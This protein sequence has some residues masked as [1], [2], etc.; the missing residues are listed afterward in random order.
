MQI[1]TAFAA[2]VQENNPVSYLFSVTQIQQI[3][4]ASCCNREGEFFDAEEEAAHHLGC[5]PRMRSSSSRRF[6]S[7][8]CIS[9]M[10]SRSR[11]S[12]AN[13]HWYGDAPTAAPLP[14]E[15][16]REISEPTRAAEVLRTW[17]QSA[18]AHTRKFGFLVTWL[19]NNFAVENK[20][21]RTRFPCRISAARHLRQATRK[22]RKF[23]KFKNFIHNREG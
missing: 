14:S 20:S 17:C 23:T 16:P 21:S 7:R 22:S 15:T 10:R 4:V 6:S 18:R 9:S 11:R 2:A 13:S 12:R 1:R 19:A 8:M 3:A 5:G